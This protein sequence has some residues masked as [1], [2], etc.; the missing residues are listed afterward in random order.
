[1]GKKK[2]TV[3][4]HSKKKENRNVRKKKRIEKCYSS[5][6]LQA[7]LNA[8]GEGQTI[9]QA[10]YNFG[11]PKS[12][13]FLK[14]KN[15]L[16]LVCKKGPKTVLSEDEENEIEQWIV[17]CAEKGFPVTKGKLLDCVQTHLK[18]KETPFKNNRPG[19]QWYSAF[20]RRHPNL[21][22]RIA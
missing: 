9:R 22:K 6:T 17:E 5:E 15:I 14:S 10:A 11:V 3:Q 2:R 21:S 19:Q 8:I 7:A 20:M 1:M 13:L 12:T 16:P 4:K 18:G